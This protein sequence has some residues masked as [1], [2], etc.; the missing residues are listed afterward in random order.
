VDDMPLAM[1]PQEAMVSAK[2]SL[3]KYFEIVD[4]R[5]VKWLLGICIKCDRKIHTITLSQTAYINT[6]VT[7]FTLRTHSK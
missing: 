2:A 1:S 3:Q 4:L 5:P 7:H 6:L